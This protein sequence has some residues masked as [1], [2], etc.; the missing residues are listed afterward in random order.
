[1]TGGS[2]A[3]NL[4][5]A[6]AKMAQDLLEGVPG[7]A[8]V[9]SF[10][11]T[12]F[13]ALRER[14]QVAFDAQGTQLQGAALLAVGGLARQEMCPHS[15]ID[16]VLLTDKAEVGP[17]R[18]EELAREVLHPVWDAGVKAQINLRSVDQW[19]DQAEDDLT[20]AS[21]LLDMRHLVGDEG[22][23][24]KAKS[25]AQRRFFG[26]ARGPFLEALSEEIRGRHRRFGTTIYRVEPDLKQ[27]IGGGRDLAILSWAL[28]ASFGS[29][30]FLAL[31]EESLLGTRAVHALARARDVILRLRTALHLAAGRA[32]ER[33]VFQYQEKL[34]Q[35]LGMVGENSDDESLV[36][37]IEDFMQQYFRAALDVLR[38]GN[39]V[40]RR[41]E[42]VSEL[43]EP[44]QLIDER[45]FTKGGFLRHYGGDFFARQPVLALE[46]LRLARKHRVGLA[47][48]TADAIIDALAEADPDALRL[49]PQAQRVL[50]DILT[51]P[52]DLGSPNSLELCHELG[53]LER[54][55]PEFAPSRGRMQ[56]EGLHIYT[57]DQH[58]LFAVDFLKGVARGEYRKNYP[59]ATAVHL[60][61][62][63][64]EPLYLGTLLHDA[65]KAFG[66]QSSQGARI[67]ATAS[68][69]AGWSKE[70]V[71][72]CEFLVQEHMLM[73]MVS[74]KRD[75][76]DPLEIS[77][78]VAN[79]QSRERLDCLY[80]ISLA[81][82]ANVS[83]QYL[84]SWKL[85]LLDELYLRSLAY[86]ARGRR[87]VQSVRMVQADEPQG[88][89]ERYYSLFDV[90]MRREHR[91]L[92]DRVWEDP[93]L[94]G[95]RCELHD[96][97][98][99][100]RL[101]VV[102]P[103]T[104][105]LLA[106]LSGTLD[107]AG[108]EIMAADVFSAPGEPTLALDIF[109]IEPKGADAFSLDHAW[110]TQVEAEIR[111]RL[112][113]GFEDYAQQG[114]RRGKRRFSPSLR[115]E[116]KTSVNFD[117]DP[118]KTRT[119][120]EVQAFGGQAVLH[121]V[122]TVTARR[123]IDIDLARLSTQDSFVE[124]ILYIDKLDKIQRSELGPAI[125]EV[126]E[127]AG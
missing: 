121:R 39:R 119:I 52:E 40:F 53:L 7:A 17:K 111:R 26:E 6:R 23:L 106:L 69:R 110:I 60:G 45:F 99:N 1:M 85:A 32:Q 89:P 58:S 98:G 3:E 72:L 63:D 122:A 49:E 120:V 29:A 73:P 87:E 84:T 113:Q 68:R 61:I 59:L 54:L 81:D 75:L 2:F 105:G 94:Q 112:A 103:D 124:L 43:V 65:G 10:S 104:R 8:V 24:E 86:F 28:G 9:H 27:G 116:G 41:C 16:L 11:Q 118:A 12:L 101:T 35:L 114:G 55:V 38:H 22:L 36:S 42:Q 34:P 66:D 19:L 13:E 46:A 92:I 100:F 77:N 14:A 56:H 5:N 76:S 18:V 102:A 47:P 127:G 108:V 25:S 97:L 107:D 48:E 90:A 93:S 67:A 109:R 51:E 71:A 44:P 126:L 83:P 57:V 95:V 15:D 91:A 117:T 79:V 78:F 96:A 31:E 33:L 30:D 125:E 115:L 82:M 37:A 4:A 20:A 62:D 123:G 80:L 88:L 74:Q 64:H 50:M 21:S 70:R